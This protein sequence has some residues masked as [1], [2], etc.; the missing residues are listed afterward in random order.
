MGSRLP[1][2]GIKD[3]ITFAFEPEVGVLGLAK[4]EFDP[5]LE[6]DP[7]LSGDGETALEGL[8]VNTE[9]GASFNKDP[10]AVGGFSPDL[11]IPP[12][13][14]PIPGTLLEAEGD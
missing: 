11:G 6:F 7:S 9:G 13:V 10:E 3:V 1:Y 14:R 12:K 5:T 4:K 8:V 2:D